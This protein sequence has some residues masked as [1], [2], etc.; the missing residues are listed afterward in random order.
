MTKDDVLRMMQE[1]GGLTRTPFDEW[2]QRFASI[3]A[4]AEREECARA[5]EAEVATWKAW[6]QAGAAK[7]RGAAAIRARGTKENK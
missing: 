2:C 1:A 4:A 7:R 3:V 6:P 5:Y